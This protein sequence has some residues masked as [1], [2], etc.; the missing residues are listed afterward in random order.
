MEIER[1]I[2][3]APRVTG[4]ELREAKIFLG[5]IL[6][7][8]ERKYTEVQKESELRGIKIR[9]MI[10]AKQELRVKKRTQRYVAYLRLPN[11]ARYGEEWHGESKSAETRYYGKMKCE[12]L[13]VICE[14]AGGEEK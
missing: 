3:N 7:K 1:K 8:G 9:A 6:S 11:D 12:W 2:R 5:E 14:E 10:K 4:E 13:K